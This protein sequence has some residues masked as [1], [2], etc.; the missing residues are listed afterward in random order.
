MRFIKEHWEGIISIFIAIFALVF[1]YRANESA[2]LQAESA[3]LEHYP[4]LA[5]VSHSNNGNKQHGI[6]IHNYSS[7]LAIVDS[8]KIN[9]ELNPKLTTEKWR[10]ILK[11]SKFEDEEIMC[12]SFSM[13]HK[14]VGVSGNNTIPL[15]F[16]SSEQEKN[17]ENSG[18]I[19]LCNS[20]KV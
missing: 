18:G 1:S 13:P 6:Y 2:K 4:Y 16:V 12:F 5:I 20:E 7:G 19:H 11:N 15:I 10:Q 9:G 3:K 8:I 14:E 17:I